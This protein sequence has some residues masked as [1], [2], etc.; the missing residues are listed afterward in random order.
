MTSKVNEYVIRMKVADGKAVEAALDQLSNTGAASFKKIQVAS[1]SAETG[2]NVFATTLIRRVIPA[3]SVVSI[4]AGIK[5]MVKDLGD[6]KDAA[7]KA[8][9]SA[10][11]LQVFRLIG[12]DAGLDELASDSAITTFTK[13]I[14]EAQQGVG[15]FKDILGYLNIELKDINGQN[16]EAAAI[17]DDFADA[18]ENTAD[19]QERLMLATKA[20]GEQGAGMV[21]VLK[22]G[23]EGLAEFEEHAKST[24]LVIDENLVNKADEVDKA[25]DTLTLK[26]QNW[27][28]E[29][30]INL[31]PLIQKGMAGIN[32]SFEMQREIARGPG[33]VE[34]QRQKSLSSASQQSVPQDPFGTFTLN[35]DDLSSEIRSANKKKTGS[36]K[37]FLDA[38]DKAEQATKKAA[39]E[40]EK[41]RDKI[42]S[43]IDALKFKNEQLLRG[44]EDQEVYTQLQAAGVD[45]TSKEGKAIEELVRA[46]QKQEEAI[47]RHINVANAWGDAWSRNFEKVL[48]DGYKLSDFLSGFLEDFGRE[49]FQE[50]IG[51]PGAKEMSD[52]VKGIVPKVED[53]FGDMFGGFRAAGGDIDTGKSYVVGEE[54]P[55][56][57]TARRNATVIPNHK[58]G[59]SGTNVTVINNVSNE[60]KT[61]VRQSKSGNAEDITILVDRIAGQKILDKSSSISRALNQRDKV[62]RINR[63]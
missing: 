56:V 42:Q 41:H 46:F 62:T 39:S 36:L 28:K 61:E 47:Q 58:L 26:I 27:F 33:W 31:I 60:V 17:L 50:Y 6:L 5:S 52:I 35:P 7:E 25:W 23:S 54:G 15:K 16:R 2:M 43:V 59:A 19:P 21:N 32:R 20:F 53:F 37:D 12:K 9:I 48:F 11:K 10:E 38:Q 22:Q 13:N 1:V 3:I 49:L 29:R 14:G 18:L 4:G 8:G 45:I 57:I 40:E 24:G 55:E 63:S 34:L 44:A 30:I 51:K